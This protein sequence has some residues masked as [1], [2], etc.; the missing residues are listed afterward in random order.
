MC[1][2]IDFARRLLFAVCM[3]VLF[4]AILYMGRYAKREKIDFN[5]VFGLLEIYRRALSRE[6]NALFW[7]VVLGVFGSTLVLL[8]SMGLYFWGL[9]E[10]CVFKLSGRWSSS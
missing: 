8:V 6:S 2:D 9:S 7:V 1:G 5:S 10:G 4:L 3:A